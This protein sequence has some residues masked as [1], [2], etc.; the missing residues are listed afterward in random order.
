M[1]F[2]T[3]S[4]YE[5]ETEKS[6]ALQEQYLDV[7]ILKKST[8]NPPVE[9][10]DG[11]DNF[12]QYNLLS[13]KSVHEPLDGWM[14]DELVGKLIS[15][16]P[17]LLLPIEQFQPYAI[18]T[19]LPHQLRREEK[20]N[21]VKKLQAG[22]YEKW[23][24]SR[25]IRIIVLNQIPPHERNALWLLFSCQAEGFTFG[26][27][28]YHWRNPRAQELLNQFYA[29]YKEEGIVMPYTLDDYYREYTVPY[30]KSL[31]VAD[32]LQGLPSEEVFKW[33]LSEHGMNKLS[34]EIIDELL[35]KLQSK[36]S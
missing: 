5:V 12:S 25:P 18:C 6:L 30:I 4:N 22:V 36:K 26:D 34:P 29:L 33:L 28:H 16:S 35:S 27:K 8:G 23:S 17:K 2:F 14:L 24:A 32:R 7:V 1:D 31:P 20:L 13:Y 3:D 9:L 11:F 10:P 21:L 15:P 19:R